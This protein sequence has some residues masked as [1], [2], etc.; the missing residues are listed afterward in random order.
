MSDTIYSAFPQF[1]LIISREVN[2]CWIDVL[3]IGET[4]VSM[5]V[6]MLGCYF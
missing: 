2:V 4:G 5:V 1:H 3:K 6:F